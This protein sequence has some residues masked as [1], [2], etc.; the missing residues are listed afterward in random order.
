MANQ[1]IGK[2]KEGTILQRGSFVANT[3]SMFSCPRFLLKGLCVDEG[4]FR[5]VQPDEADCIED[6]G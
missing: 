3:S 6:D 1:R 4:V 5:R 2:T